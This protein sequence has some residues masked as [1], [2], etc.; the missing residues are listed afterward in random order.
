M[1]GFQA[2]NSA[3]K[4]HGLP[5]VVVVV[6]GSVVVVDSSSFCTGVYG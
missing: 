2:W 3:D 6:G 4:G 1:P 5:D